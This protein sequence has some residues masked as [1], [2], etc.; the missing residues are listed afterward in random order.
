[1]TRKK[2]KKKTIEVIIIMSSM[3]LFHILTLY[4]LILRPNIRSYHLV[5]D[6]SDLGIVT[7]F[8]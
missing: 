3:L 5:L 1:M 8:C 2:K 7:E 6:S 4:N